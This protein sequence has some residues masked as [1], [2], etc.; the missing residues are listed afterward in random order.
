LASPGS[1]PS[2]FMYN[3]IP[4]SSRLVSMI[5]ISHCATT[6]EV[7]TAIYGLSTYTTLNLIFTS[8]VVSNA[9]VSFPLY[10]LSISSYL[11]V[12]VV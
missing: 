7:H 5:F 9:E 11:H 6:M 1:S 12:L 2:A 10:S 4:F 3:S 8:D